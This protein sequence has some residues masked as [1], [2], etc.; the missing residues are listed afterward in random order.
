MCES[1]EV[2]YG[3]Y[4]LFTSTLYDDYYRLLNGSTQV[5]STEVNSI[6]VPSKDIIR[7]MG[8]ELM[9][10]EINETNCNLITDKWIK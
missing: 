3:L 7:K 9:N 5:N 10:T 2:V 4:A 8:R 1:E 6:P